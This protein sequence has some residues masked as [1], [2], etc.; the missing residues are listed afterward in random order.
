MVPSPRFQLK[1]CKA[2]LGLSQQISRRQDFAG[3]KLVS[4][5]I[6]TGLRDLLRCELFPIDDGMDSCTIKPCNAALF[7]IINSPKFWWEFSGTLLFLFFRLFFFPPHVIMNCRA[8]MNYVMEAE[9]SECVRFM[10]A[11]GQAN[12]VCDGMMDCHDFSDEVAC[13]YCPEG[14]V[15]CGV[16]AACIDVQKRCDG[17]PDCPNGSDERGCCKLWPIYLTPLSLCL[18]MGFTGATSSRPLA[19]RRAF[20]IFSPWGLPTR[21][22][23]I[24]DLELWLAVSGLIGM[25]IR[26]PFASWFLRFCLEIEGD[27]WL[28][29]SHFGS[30]NETHYARISV[31]LFTWQWRWL[32]TWRR[33]ISSINTFTRDTSSSRKATTRGK[34]VSTR[35]TPPPSCPQLASKVF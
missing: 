20:A 12:R 32:P 1:R 6:A 14:Q 23:I 21:P 30:T 19:Y 5:D 22:V 17:V 3:N 11:N 4:S 34:Y 25:M 18:C 33:L 16:G 26:P 31:I 2:R 10:T 29:F 13:N 28:S 27:Y 35:S 24:F 15:H 8:A 7:S 9:P